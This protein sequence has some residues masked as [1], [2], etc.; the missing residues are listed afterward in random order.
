MM[1]YTCRYTK[2]ATDSS[3]YAIALKWPD[4]NILTLGLVKT[5]SNSVVTLLGYGKVQL[6]TNTKG[7]MEITMPPLPLDSD[8]KWAW[9]FKLEN[10]SPAMMLRNRNTSRSVL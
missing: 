3:V 2:N 8:L 1:V 10:I 6:K 9:T 7:Q 4:N 5:T